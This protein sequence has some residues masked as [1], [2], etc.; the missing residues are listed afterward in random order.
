[1]KIKSQK[2][3]AA[4]IAKASKKRVKLDYT[5]LEEIKESITKSDIRNLI[6]DKVI[7][8]K[9]KK[10]VSRVRAKKIQAQKRK[11]RRK[12]PGK[13]KSKI[14][15]RI[16]KKRRW[17]NKIRAQ[18]NFLKKLKETKNINNENY[19]ILY[20][21]SKGGFFRN[22]RHIKVYIQEHDLVQKK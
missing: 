11:G 17:I 4:Q 7:V 15:A 20:L 16:S 3:L 6:K 2:R 10:G 22:I 1:M 19:R 5:K 21:K 13:K 18:R 14:N 8:I 12:G 9:Q